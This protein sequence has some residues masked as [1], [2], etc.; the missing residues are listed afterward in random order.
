MRID[1]LPN[2][3]GSIPEMGN[4]KP[5]G[6]PGREN[7]SFF[8][9]ID[10]ITSFAEPWKQ[11]GEVEPAR[12]VDKA[13]DPGC[14]HAVA[15]IL[16]FGF[17]NTEIQNYSTPDSSQSLAGSLHIPDQSGPA[18]AGTA[19]VAA[20]ASSSSNQT[21]TGEGQPAS[22]TTSSASPI[23]A[24]APIATEE[25]P[26]VPIP[27]PATEETTSFEPPAAV[28]ASPDA[29][30]DSTSLTPPRP[31]ADV[32]M[33]VD[34][35]VVLPMPPVVTMTG[36]SATT[37][38]AAVNAVPPVL[39][40]PNPAAVLSLSNAPP[41][42]QTL[43][44]DA[45]TSRMPL[46]SFDSA[47][48]TP[49][50]RVAE[51]DVP[52][53]IIPSVSDAPEQSDFA[54]G[55]HNLEPMDFGKVEPL[56]SDP[57]TSQPTRIWQQSEQAYVKPMN[58]DAP[59]DQGMILP[60]APD[61][62]SS[63]DVAKLSAIAAS[64]D[65]AKPG[66]Q[67]SLRDA[68]EPIAA[69]PQTDSA[70][71]W[72][73]GNDAAGVLASAIVT[74]V[75][76]AAITGSY[77]LPAASPPP[78]PGVRNPR[79]PA[80]A[81]TI[82]PADADSDS[83]LSPLSARS[84]AIDPETLN[85]PAYAKPAAA[86]TQT[87]A[88]SDAT[89][90]RPAAGNSARAKTIA[91]SMSA[92]A[93]PSY[94][95][96]TPPAPPATTDFM[97]KDSQTFVRDSATPLET[98]FGSAASLEPDSNLATLN[99]T[100]TP[101][102]T[103]AP[104]TL[105]GIS[106][107]L[108]SSGPADLD[109]RGLQIPVEGAAIPAETIQRTD[110]VMG[111]DTAE[112]ENLVPANPAQASAAASIVDPA[113]DASDPESG[114]PQTEIRIPP[115]AAAP[116]QARD[117]DSSNALAANADGAGPAVPASAATDAATVTVQTISDLT[118]AG[119]SLALPADE[120][121]EEEEPKSRMDAAPAGRGNSHPA[122]ILR[123]M[124]ALAA[125]D[126]VS[127]G[128]SSVPSVTANPKADSEKA[129]S[130]APSQEIDAA[131]PAAPD[132]TT[133]AGPV[134]SDAS[135][136][137]PALANPVSAA[138]G[139]N[140]GNKRAAEESQVRGSANS[141]QD[142]HRLDKAPGHAENTVMAPPLAAES[143]STEMNSESFAD[144]VGDENL[145]ESLSQASND[146]KKAAAAP[147]KEKAAEPDAAAVDSAEFAWVDMQ[148]AQRMLF[149]GQ[150]ARTSTPDAC[151]FAA[152][153]PVQHAVSMNS[154]SWTAA[155]Q[156]PQQAAGAELKALLALLAPKHN[157]PSQ[158]TDFLSQLS[159]RIQMQLRDNQNILTIQLKP[160][161]LGRV[162]IKAE[163]SG[164]GVLAT[165]VTE[166]ASVKDYL[167]NNLHLLQQNF[168]DQ[169]LKIDRINVTVQEGFW[170]QQPSSGH[171]ESRSDSGQQGDSRFPASGGSQL[172]QASE[173]LALDAQTILD[174]NPHSTFH[175]IA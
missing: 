48:K 51:E 49:V 157:A 89:S 30:L 107:R 15:P 68:P 2:T 150:L 169:G 162:E 7:N 52:V 74:D 58:A 9:V 103:D 34:L 23:N 8:A 155:G 55:R 156:S 91:S 124:S 26:A 116:G 144:L 41:N 31:S 126:E 73:V 50:V 171:H 175:A 129:A 35:S 98:V 109:A 99:P 101:S 95:R 118:P 53:A 122:G 106:A 161:S 36:P 13:D 87:T 54:A 100:P 56:L 168:Q 127:R 19:D 40:N 102:G 1:I 146:T 113:M 131:E 140:A 67:T 132:G 83:E 20:S 66:S 147:G 17:V 5:E 96:A 90:A 110:I 123:M 158:T 170:H 115:A 46:P 174:M 173:E 62:S 28:Q 82:M 133:S 93:A 78:D 104:A 135:G 3:A 167:E 81:D 119:S 125:S 43:T 11:D 114:G 128:I 63:P 120:P 70:P 29:A 80:Q 45:E 65:L 154:T 37:S 163:T 94:E 139:K 121:A 76:A 165:I 22:E 60:P 145:P 6:D 88:P 92:G 148:N 105:S 72:Q 108:R 151:V 38:E 39:L 10:Q 164:S 33:Q 172:G 79:T 14:D 21:A 153:R 112:T 85:V 18:R 152:L 166:S 64:S 57:S 47:Q 142:G 84:I 134:A 111:Q 24:A 136:T 138:P 77:A 32:P 61:G 12:D 97:V 27:Q 143:G 75:D 117:L 141:T 149:H 59:H 4:P 71:A 69:L 160:S 86:M 25:T 44:I 42:A 130:E 16:P 159:E 137:Q